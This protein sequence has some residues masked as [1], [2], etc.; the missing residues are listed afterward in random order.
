MKTQPVNQDSRSQGTNARSG[1]DYENKQVILSLS[2]R[3]DAAAKRMLKM[4]DDPT[5]SMK[6]Q[7]R[8]TE[9]P[10][11]KRAFLRENAPRQAK[12]DNNYRLRNR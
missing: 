6:T 1:H 11:M 12:I 5:I 3:C 9:C 7:G 8:A 4:K 2:R 10:S